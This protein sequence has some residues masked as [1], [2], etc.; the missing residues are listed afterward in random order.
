VTRPEAVRALT[1]L[2]RWG[3]ALG[4]GVVLVI[5]VSVRLTFTLRT[6]GGLVGLGNYDDG[7][8]SPLRS[9]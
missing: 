4:L 3:F 2:Q 6:P 7:V 5:A 1:W 8:T 9:G